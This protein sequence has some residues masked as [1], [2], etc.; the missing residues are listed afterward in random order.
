MLAKVVAEAERRGEREL[1]EGEWVL[2]K[3]GGMSSRPKTKL[4]SRYMGPY[5]VVNRPNPTD[6]IVECQHL[7][8]KRVCRF[9]MSELQVVTLDHYASVADAAPIAL[10]DEWTYMID[11]IVGHRPTGNRKLGSGRLRPKQSYSFLVKYALLPESNEVGEENPCWQPWRN[12][13]HL[14]ALR[15]YCAKPE[16]SRE[17]GQNFYVSDGEE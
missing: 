8:S 13:Q 14:S 3:R 4:Q 11:S 2:V 15:D 1:C 12:C 5:L 9:H 10:R 7:A 17:L 6:S 16:V